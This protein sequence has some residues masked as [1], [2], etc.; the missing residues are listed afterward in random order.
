MPTKSQSK[1][2]ATP[3]AWLWVLF[4]SIWHRSAHPPTTPASTQTKIEY[5]YTK[6]PCK[7]LTQYDVEQ[8]VDELTRKLNACFTPVNH[9]RGRRVAQRNCNHQQ[10]KDL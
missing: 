6:V 8:L 9:G 2:Q 5:M 10:C 7:W 1:L 4:S 3:A